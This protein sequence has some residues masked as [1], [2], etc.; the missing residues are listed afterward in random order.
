M[1]AHVTWEFFSFSV[2]IKQSQFGVFKFINDGIESPKKK[3]EAKKEVSSG[4][5]HSHTMSCVMFT[6]RIRWMT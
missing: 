1:R 5:S 3:G 2:D 6:N 4:Q